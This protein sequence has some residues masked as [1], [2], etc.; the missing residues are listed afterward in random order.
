M[1][2]RM[3][4]HGPANSLSGYGQDVIGLVRALIEAGVQVDLWPSSILPPVPPE[5]A[6]LMTRTL[7]PPYDAVLLYNPPAD[8]TPWEFSGWGDK[9]IGWTMCESTP[10]QT[11]WLGD[12]YDPEDPD[13]AAGHLWSRR[14]RR[15]VSGPKG[16][17]DLLLVTCPMNVDAFAALDPHVPI[18][19]LTPGLRI[20]DWPE[21]RR[22]RDPGAPVVF[23]CE[24]VLGGRK[25]PATL[26]KAWDGF[27]AMYPGL[28]SRLEL[29]V[30]GDPRECRARAAARDD[31][32]VHVGPWS[33]RQ[34][35]DWYQT[36]DCWVSTSRGEGVNKPAVQALATGMPV[37]AAPWGGHETWMHPDHS[38][39]ADYREVATGDGD[40]M[41]VEVDASHVAELM[42]E[43]A[44]DPQDRR[45]KGAS[46]ARFVA[47]SLGWDRQVGELLRLVG[48]A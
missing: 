25:D 20:E 24:G 44:L 35:L 38:Y 9:L 28:D 34:E 17:L 27:R 16:W 30:A 47:A 19:V 31:V 10:A 22:D 15:A 32:V 18:E 1:T 37:I 42:G 36:V 23:G 43:A 2:L 6:A 14:P 11:G 39:A 4:V 45:R 48:R 13:Q 7:A 12:W 33:Q 3:L 40:A 21:L 8:I 26:F 5:V 29:H 46:G 41:H